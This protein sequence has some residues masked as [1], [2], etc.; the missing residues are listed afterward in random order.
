MR[1]AVDLLVAQIDLV[2]VVGLEIELPLA[3]VALEASLVVDVASDGPDALQSVHQAAAAETLFGGDA[4]RARNQRRRH[5]Y[6]G[7]VERDRV[8]LDA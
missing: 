4:L 7:D 8:R 6:A 5:V 2:G 1:L 3:V